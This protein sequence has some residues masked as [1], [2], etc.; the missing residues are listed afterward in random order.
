MSISEILQIVSTLKIP[1]WL[2]VTGSILV[3]AFWVNWPDSK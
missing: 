3:F 1:V 2:W